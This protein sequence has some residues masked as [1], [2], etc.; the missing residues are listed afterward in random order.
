MDKTTL[1]RVLEKH[2]AWLED[3]GGKQADLHGVDLR[4]VC[5][6]GADLRKVDLSDADLCKADLRNADLCW[7]IICKED[8][9]DANLFRGCLVYPPLIYPR[10]TDK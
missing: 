2:K 5:L 4:R 1:V 8:L 3:M 7:E 10:R 9:F 6:C